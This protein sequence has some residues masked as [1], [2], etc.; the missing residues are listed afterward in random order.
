MNRRLNIFVSYS[1]RDGM[2]TSELLQRVH[3][4]LIGVCNPFIHSVERERLKH[5]Q[6][7]V[8][9]ALFRAHVLLLIVSP[10]VRQSPW[11]RFELL[12]GR[13]RLLPV[14][15]LEVVEMMTWKA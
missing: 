1:S 3:G 6:W 10:G 12:M 7:A 15:R 5:Q 13:L 2:V 11:V 4:Q 8:I 14:I 9:K